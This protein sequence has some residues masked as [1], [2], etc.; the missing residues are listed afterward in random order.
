M[1]IDNQEVVATNEVMML[2]IDRTQ[3]RVAP[4]PKHY[5]NAIQDYA[6]KKKNEWPP[7]LGHS[8]G[9]PHKGE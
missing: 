2:G 1:L 9:I 3:R 8:I 5:L 7:Q 6:H 4:F